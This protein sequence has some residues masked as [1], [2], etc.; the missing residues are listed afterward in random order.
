MELNNTYQ[1]C[2]TL[3]IPEPCL[4]S[5]STTD[6][7]S[8]KTNICYILAKYGL[9]VIAIPD[10]DKKGIYLSQIVNLIGKAHEHNHQ[11][12]ALWHIRNGGE[13]GQETLARSHSRDEFVLHTDCSYEEEIPDFIGLQV[14]QH[15]VYGGGNNLLVKADD[16]IRDLSPESLKTLQQQPYHFMVPEEFRK[17]K[18]FIKATIIDNQFNIR[19]R[20]EIID[21]ENSTCSQITAL[22]ELEKLTYSA[23]L[24][25]KLSL[26]KNNILLLN[27]RKFLHARTKIIDPER[28][29]IRIRFFLTAKD[30]V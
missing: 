24:N 6:Y 13:S 21:I 22:N 26:N 25:Y 16:L 10:G 14:V 3:K 28:H 30:E 15:D 5:L 19:Y 11:Q 17:D 29:L 18:E 4:L 9:V 12:S 1:Q 27:N 23:S 20:R 2:R 8:L 7:S